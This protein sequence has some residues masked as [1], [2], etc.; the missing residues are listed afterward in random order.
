MALGAATELTKS[1]GGTV[2]KTLRK[3]VRD[4]QVSGYQVKR[5]SKGHL[6]VLRNGRVVTGF[7]GTPSDR[8]SW[9][10]SL[11]PLK[12]DGFVANPGH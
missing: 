1:I 4:L 7:A 2:S 8:R 11:A 12:R 5:T 3:L 6:L 9:N 10:N